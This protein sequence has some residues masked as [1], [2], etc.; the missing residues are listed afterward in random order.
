MESQ[1]Y[2]SLDIQQENSDYSLN[3]KYLSELPLAK[4]SLCHLKCL[5]IFEM[6]RENSEPDSPIRGISCKI[7][8]TIV[9]NTVFKPFPMFHVAFNNDFYSGFFCLIRSHNLL[10]DSFQLMFA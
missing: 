6:K 5:S 1:A 3:S 2:L 7:S 9:L 8:F 4:V 10:H